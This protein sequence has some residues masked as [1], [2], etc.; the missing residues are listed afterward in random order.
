MPNRL[1]LLYSKIYYKE[2]NY[3]KIKTTVFKYITPPYSKGWVYQY[4]NILIFWVYHILTFPRSELLYI[5]SSV[6]WLSYPSSYGSTSSISS[7]FYVLILTQYKSLFSICTILFIKSVIANPYHS[8]VFLMYNMTSYGL[9]IN[10]INYN[11]L[12]SL[13]LLSLFL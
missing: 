8:P 11:N 2:E 7:A 6:I 9:L 10:L 12:Y 1:T 3:L 13:Y 5:L 4:V